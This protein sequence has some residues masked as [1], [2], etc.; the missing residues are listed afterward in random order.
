MLFACT[1]VVFAYYYHS[2]IV[3]DTATHTVPLLT[4]SAL[5]I[6]KKVGSGTDLEANTSVAAEETSTT[7]I[8]H[9]DRLVKRIAGNIGTFGGP[10]RRGSNGQC[11]HAVDI[12]QEV[13][14]RNEDKGEEERAEKP[15]FPTYGKSEDWAR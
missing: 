5:G 10:L 9:R 1:T 4:Q 2:A 7:P 14:E 3:A 8:K 12:K 15:V 11:D 6:H 13:S